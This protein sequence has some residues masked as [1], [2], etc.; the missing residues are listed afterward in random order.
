MGGPYRNS[1]H[2]AGVPAR[3]RSRG[4][5][6]MELVVTLGLL[7]LLAM[8][9]APLAELE[10]Q[11]EREAALRSA[12]HD[13]RDAIDRYKQAA[14]KGLI[15]RKVGD[16]GYPPSLRV[17]VEGVPNQRSPTGEKFY[18]LRRVPRDPFAP[19]TALPEDS[20]DLRSH[21]SAADAPSPGDDVYDVHSRASGTGLNG[22]PYQRW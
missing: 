8:L 22:L 15:Q 16:S 9:A 4:F 7:A 6:L 12:L 11:R 2:P 13:M 10:V 5:T 18:F 21:A 19:P 14:D 20:W 1:P 17:L 3:S